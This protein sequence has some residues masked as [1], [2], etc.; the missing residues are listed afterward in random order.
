MAEAELARGDRRLNIL[1]VTQ[2]FFP[3]SFRINDLVL[4]LLERGHA[5][6]VLAGTPNYPQGSYFPGYGVFKQARSDFHGATVYRVPIVPRGQASAL[7]LFANYLSYAISAS[8]LGPLLCRGRFDI[9]FTFQMSPVTVGIPALVLRRLKR[10]PMIFWVQDLWPESLV[11][12]S[13]I[14]SPRVLRLVDWLVAK[15]YRGSDLILVQSRAFTESLRRHGADPAKV[16]YF[17]N[18]AESFYREVEVAADDPQAE[19]L[20]KGFRVM[21]AGNIGVAQDFKTILAAA[22]LLK[23][24]PQ[25]KWVI[26]GDGSQRKW[27]ESRVQELGLQQCVSLIGSFAPQAMPKLFALADGLL[28]TLKSDP[29]FEVTIPSKL[30]SYLA[31]GKPIIA[32]L[33]GEGARIITEA[34]AGFVAPTESAQ[35][36]ARAV[37][38]LYEA[39][40]ARRIAMGRC[41]RE[42][43]LEHFEREQLLDSLLGWMH[44]LVGGKGRGQTVQACVDQATAAKT[45]NSAADPALNSKETGAG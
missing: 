32:A 18:T 28:V 26:A 36:L 3:E 6:T 10:L 12:N 39:A 22:L 40:P 1:V 30:Q 24:H 5:V 23:D 14:R 44:A 35:A 27:V 19:R 37:L 13:G 41:A 9:V 33:D 8:L 15:L 43:F 2:Y 21:F 16:R 38:D 7:G 34:G 11:A 20:P 42:Y 25:I 29:I 17:P 31:C 45:G 4:G